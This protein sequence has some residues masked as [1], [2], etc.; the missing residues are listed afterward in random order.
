M[1]TIF[2]CFY[3]FSF[4]SATSF[5]H[6]KAMAINVKRPDSTAVNGEADFACKLA[7]R[8]AL[9]LLYGSSEQKKYPLYK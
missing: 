8:F 9:Y 7:L 1:Y 3:L 6:T 4:L 2:M 5:S